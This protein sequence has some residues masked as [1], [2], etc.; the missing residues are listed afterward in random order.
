MHPAP[1]WAVRA[2]YSS[3]LEADMAL[4]RLEAA[5]IPAMRAP[6]EATGVFGPGFSGRSSHGV[7]VLV[8]EGALAAAHELLAPAVELVHLPFRGRPARLAISRGAAGS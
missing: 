7:T 6:S 5:E 4:S 8:P 2:T 3:Q 1:G